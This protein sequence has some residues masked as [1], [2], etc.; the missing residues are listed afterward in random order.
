MESFARYSPMH[1]LLSK[2]EIVALLRGQG[3][4]YAQACLVCEYSRTATFP[5]SIGDIILEPRGKGTF[6]VFENHEHVD[7]AT[8]VG[9]IA[10]HA[11]GTPLHKK[12]AEIVLKSLTGMPI[13]HCSE[14]LSAAKV[15]G[16]RS[17]DK[18]SV[19]Y[20]SS[21]KKYVVQYIPPQTPPKD[22]DEEPPVT[23]PTDGGSV[24]SGFPTV[25]KLIRGAVE[26]LFSSMSWPYY[27]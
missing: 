25:G 27:P 7:G 16:V 12:P 26:L 10:K 6:D 18:Y 9:R 1:Q 17:T 22:P 21:T 4:T 19:K 23:P 13:K 11:I 2:S 3:I 8:Y 15:D 14:A 24:D 5:Q 20:V